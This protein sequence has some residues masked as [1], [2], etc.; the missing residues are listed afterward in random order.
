MTLHS[1]DQTT[2]RQ[3]LVGEVSDEAQRQQVEE[4]LLTDGDFFQ[5]LE[6]T[7]D[8]LIDQYLTG[9]LTADERRNFESHFLAAP[10][11][12]RK[13][14]FARALRK[15]VEAAAVET[16]QQQRSQRSKSE[17]APLWVRLLANPYL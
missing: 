13:L 11:R 3:Y 15:C 5:E 9:A 14:S 7:E 4:R 10:E 16:R 8:E 2:V 1:N 12:Q 6:I 17:Q